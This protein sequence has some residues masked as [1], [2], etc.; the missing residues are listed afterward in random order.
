MTIDKEA[1][2]KLN[3]GLTILYLLT[4]QFVVF[5]FLLLVFLN[6]IIKTPYEL[7][8]LIFKIILVTMTIVYYSLAR[9]KNAS[10]AYRLKYKIYAYA[11]AGFILEIIVLY[12]YL[13]LIGV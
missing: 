6:Y 11:F 3:K 2:D 7:R 4:V 13:Y 10:D 1:P 12:A 8:Q 5:I 9:R